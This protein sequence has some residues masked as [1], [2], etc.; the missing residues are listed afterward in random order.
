MKRDRIKRIKADKISRGEQV[1]EAA[2]GGNL[3]EQDVS[4]SSKG[5]NLPEQDISI[6]VREAT[7]PNKM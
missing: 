4:Y 7:S 6:T 2:I 3:P 5:G 1:D